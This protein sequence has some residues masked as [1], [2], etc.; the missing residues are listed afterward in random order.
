VARSNCNYTNVN[1]LTSFEKNLQLTSHHYNTSNHS[2]IYVGAEKSVME[3]F[4][5]Y[6][7]K[8]V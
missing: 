5:K 3:H 2:H 6:M 7:Q 4:W 1:Y 8:V